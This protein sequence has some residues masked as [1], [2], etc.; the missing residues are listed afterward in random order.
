MKAKI[1]PSEWEVLNALWDRAPVTAADVYEALSHET[2]WHHKTVNTFLARLAG[3]G[4]VSIR[5]EG[6]VNV[7]TPNL[8]RE[9]CVRQESESF[10]RRVFRGAT[11]PLLAHFC[12]SADLSND[13]I[14]RLQK[15]L[16]QRTK[17]FRK[18]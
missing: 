9:Q 7:Y 3:K 14:A 17:K 11:G 16:Q 4:I 10:L 15:I 18:K 1:S 12:E 8:T 5:R 6:K 13:E 2:D